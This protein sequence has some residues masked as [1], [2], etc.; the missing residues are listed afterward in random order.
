MDHQYISSL[1][2]KEVSRGASRPRRL[3]KL[4]RAMRKGWLKRQDDKPLEKPPVYLLWQDDGL[5][6][7]HTQA[8]ELRVSICAVAKRHR[9]CC[10]SSSFDARLGTLPP[11]LLWLNTY[12]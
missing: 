4:V 6:A 1:L 7:D 12:R 9:T 3:V 8:G 2:L 10:Q 11:R 5:A